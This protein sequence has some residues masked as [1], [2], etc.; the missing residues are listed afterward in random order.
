MKSILLFVS[1]LFSTFLSAQSIC[2]T[3]SMYG[4]DITEPKRHYWSNMIVRRDS[5]R[6]PVDI[7]VNI[8]RQLASL[9]NKFLKGKLTFKRVFVN[10]DN[11]ELHDRDKPVLDKT[12][13]PVVV[14][15]RMVYEL[16]IDSSMT[17]L[18]GA[19][20]DSKGNFLDK[21]EIPFALKKSIPKII[22]CEQA[23]KKAMAVD[24]KIKEFQS[25]IVYYHPGKETLEWGFTEKFTRREQKVLSQVN[26]NATTGKL[27]SVNKIN[28][29][30]TPIL[31]EVRISQ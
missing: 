8:N 5:S 30:E 24:K 3:V 13:K 21:K 4:T 22:S 23:L 14:K 1:I 19:D 11:R 2:S 17:I 10:I 6:I 12:G 16:A 25:V 26:I 27:S 9:P 7:R 29:N 31:E 15:Y 28:L 20:M 18:F